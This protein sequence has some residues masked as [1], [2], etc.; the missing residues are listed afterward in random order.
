MMKKIVFFI[1][2][3]LIGFVANAQDLNRTDSQGR[4]QGKWVD[5]YSNGQIRY[6]GQFKNGNCQGEFKYY[7]EQGNLKATNEFDK[8]G[9]R[10]L[11]KTYAPNGRVIATGDYLNQKKDGEWKYYDANSGQLRLVEDNKEG[12][13]HGWSRIYNPQ[14]GALAEETQFVGGVPEGQCRKYSDT[15]TLIMECQY[16]EGLLEGPTK[17]YYPS[18]ALKEEG[19]YTKGKKSGTWKTY[20]EEGDVIAEE[21]FGDFVY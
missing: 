16:H 14:N 1:L 2:T 3:L 18:T 20:N 7:D 4:R 15:G 10:A 11:N 21:V 6:E 17:T 9:E 19:Q 5:Y 8:S 13:V 12:K